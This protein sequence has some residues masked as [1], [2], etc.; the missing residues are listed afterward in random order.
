[1]ATLGADGRFVP[2]LWGRCVSYLRSS[3]LPYSRLNLEMQRGA[4]TSLLDRNTK[5]LDPEG[6]SKRVPARCIMPFIEEEPLRGDDRPALKSAVDFCKANNTILIL[7][8]FDR[9]RGLMRWLEYLHTQR[10]QFI[11]ADAPHINQTNYFDLV[12]AEEARRD[13]VGEAIKAGLAEARARGQ[14]LGGKRKNASGLKLG[15]KASAEWRS[16]LAKTEARS[17]MREIERVRKQGATSLTDIASHLNKD[18]HPAPRGRAW[19]PAQVR[20]VIK[21][22][23]N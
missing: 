1:M 11:A 17:T 7:A 12:R 2:R 3:S 13:N 16:Y 22:L 19:S 6:T 15:P 5:R 14:A 21:R 20:R 23:E 18:G 10:V 8:K 9:I 4:V